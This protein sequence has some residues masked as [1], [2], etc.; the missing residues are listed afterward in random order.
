MSNAKPIDILLVEDNPGDVDLMSE[1]FEDAHVANN[2]FVVEDGEE[3]ISFLTRT[4]AYTEKPRPDIIL[5]DLNLPKKNGHEVLAFIKT[6]DDLRRIPVIVLTSSEADKDIIKSY[7]LH[8]NSF[9]TKPVDLDKFL[10]VIKTLEDF[11]LRIVKLPN[12]T[13]E[14]R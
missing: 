13:P 8:A 14:Q 9:I 6:H 2:L 1:A 3:A 5:L 7:N 10:E 4:G 11:W 12:R